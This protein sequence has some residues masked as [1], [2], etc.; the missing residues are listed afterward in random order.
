[1]LDWNFSV[2]VCVCTCVFVLCV[3][4][5]LCACLCVCVCVCVCHYLGSKLCIVVTCHVFIEICY[6]AVLNVA[7]IKHQMYCSSLNMKMLFKH[8][9]GSSSR[10]LEVNV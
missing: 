8:V 10:L 6:N 3:C 2:C 4:V 9:G 1:M 5:C 7:I